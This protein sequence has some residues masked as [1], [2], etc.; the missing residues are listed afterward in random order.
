MPPPLI[1][2][3]QRDFWMRMRTALLLAVDAIE[4]LLCISPRTAELRKTNCINKEM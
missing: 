1:Q 3:F 4:L 2:I